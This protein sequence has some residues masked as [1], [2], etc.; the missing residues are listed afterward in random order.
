VTQHVTIGDPA[1]VT[2]RFVTAPGNLNS[3]P[4]QRKSFADEQIFDI[5]AEHG[6]PVL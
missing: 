6:P 4:R 5:L 1:T 2:M 3:A